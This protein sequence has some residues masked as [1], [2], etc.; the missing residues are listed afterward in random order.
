MYFAERQR[1]EL[2]ESVR[3]AYALELAL[4]NRLAETCRRLCAERITVDL[5]AAK[6]PSFPE[7]AEVRLAYLAE[8][9]SHV[10]REPGGKAIRFHSRGGVPVAH[11]ACELGHVDGMPTIEEVVLGPRC[12]SDPTSI[13]I[14]LGTLGLGSVK[15]RKSSVPYR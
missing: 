1:Q 10:L 14:F 15:V 5:V 7:E 9:R 11:V 13:K 4:P 12:A 8:V 2:A 6:N 3:V